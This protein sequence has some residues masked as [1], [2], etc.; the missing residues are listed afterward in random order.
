[1]T[2]HASLY[3]HSDNEP[4]IYHNCKY[5][6]IDLTGPIV[7]VFLTLKVNFDILSLD[8]PVSKCFRISSHN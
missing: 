6:Q 4:H 1:M 3:L 2:K 7:K 5:L 8:C